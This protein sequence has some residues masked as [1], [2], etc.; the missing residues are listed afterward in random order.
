LVLA[1]VAGGVWWS[2]SASDA[3]R[4][5][6]YV[7][8]GASDAVGVGA[9]VPS[10]DGWA[11]RVHAG[12]GDGTRLVNLGINGA[13][14]DDVVQLELP[15]ALDA[16]PTLVTIWPGVNDLRAGVPLDRFAA[17]LDV[18]LGALGELDSVTLVVV[19]IPDLR[20][21]PEFTNGD[22]AALDAQVRAWNVAIS[23]AAS[24]HAALL[25]DLY[26]P[27]LEL[28][29]HP[30]YVSADG[31]HPSTAGYR[32]IAELTLAVIEGQ[33]VQTAE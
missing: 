26:G 33:H 2:R 20:Y 32:R 15:V 5:N 24:R 18:L 23:A 3:V 8:L 29:T 16:R 27:A 11:A 7:A 14:L 12:L 9:G 13:T 30:V 31:F 28:A 19:T 17:R 10:R 22:L 6:V 25:V 21:V 1:G 4:Q